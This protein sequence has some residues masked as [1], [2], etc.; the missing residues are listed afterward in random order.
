MLTSPLK[1]LVL[2]LGSAMLLQGCVAAAIGG[3]AV[4]G[5]TKVATD[6][7]SMGTQL[8]DET[9]ESRVNSAIKKD[10]Q[11]KSEARISVTAYSGR[12]LLTGQVPNENLR[13]V[14]SS[15]AKGVQNVND[16][17]NEV[18]VG[19][20]V[21]FAQI[22]KDSWITSQIKSKMLVDSKVKTSDVK[23][24]TENNE[25]FLMGNVTQDQGNAAAEIARNVAGVTKVI[26]VFNYLN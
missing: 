18:R 17:Y 14:A 6:P 1:K 2:V 8:D 22:S 15:L 5:A 25:V 3:A 21:D 9:L 7:R 11:I 13:E 23:V 4:A 20:K 16:V 10:Q 26:K 19:P 12:I 24:V